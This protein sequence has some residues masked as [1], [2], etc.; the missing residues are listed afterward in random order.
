[1]MLNVDFRRSVP[2]AGLFLLFHFS[3]AK[4][5]AASPDVPKG[6]QQLLPRG[7]IG[8]IDDPR[9]V[10]AAQSDIRRDAW[11]LGVVIDGQARAYSLDLLNAH[12]VVNDAI[13]ETNFAAVW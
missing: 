2:L 3:P 4:A 11:V 9:Y 1:M 6:F 12:E 7:G 13:G 10:P 8:A 5:N